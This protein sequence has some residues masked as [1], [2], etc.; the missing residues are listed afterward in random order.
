M[1]LIIFHL[2]VRTNTVIVVEDAKTIQFSAALTHQV[3]GCSR[4]REYFLC[5]LLT[6]AKLVKIPH[7]LL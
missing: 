5:L 4:D 6:N 7:Q 1:M 3:G 2:N